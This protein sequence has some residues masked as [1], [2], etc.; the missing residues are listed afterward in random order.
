MAMIFPKSCSELLLNKPQVL[1]T[2]KDLSSLF[3]SSR[4]LFLVKR[5]FFNPGIK[6]SIQELEENK[7]LNSSSSLL[8]CKEAPVPVDSEELECTHTC[9]REFYFG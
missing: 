7:G 4:K 2:D 6:K 9:S 1:H 8:G 3:T 5:L